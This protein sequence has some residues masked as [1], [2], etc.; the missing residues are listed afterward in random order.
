M[1]SSLANKVGERLCEID[2]KIMSLF[3]FELVSMTADTAVVQMTVRPDMVN[4]HG[5]CHGGLVFA[6]ADHAF[7]YACMASNQAGVTLSANVIYSNPAKLD[8]RLTAVG[9]V[10]T[11]GGRTASCQVL[12]RNQKDE[13]VAQY[14]GVNYRTKQ[15]IV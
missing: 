2:Q 5:Y 12:V 10:T 7:A 1:N 4:I 15:Q 3:G 9:Q 14:Q 13:I 8:D 11:A 6:L